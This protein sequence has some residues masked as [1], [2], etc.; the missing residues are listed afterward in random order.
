MINS[1][2]DITIT[3]NEDFSE[4]VQSSD[5][6]LPYVYIP[7][8]FTRIECETI[9]EYWNVDN[10]F[11]EKDVTKDSPWYK[12]FREE[13]SRQ[14][15]FLEKPIQWLDSKLCSYVQK[16]NAENFFLDITFGLNSKQLM[17]YS[18]GDWFQPHDDTGHWDNNYYDR[19]ITAIVQLS[20]GADYEGGNTVVEIDRDIEQPINQK[21]LGSMLIF[22]TF[23]IHE[24]KEITEG[25]R[26]SFICW[27]NGP[28]FR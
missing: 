21:D 28:K 4:Y 16:A 14:H 22:P 6:R 12:Y 20:D 25:Y 5:C 7:N 24:V 9:W 13:R 26:K 15:M 1:P 27:F 18:K 23:A 2:S 19:K 17:L 11:T 10:V 8:A 3:D